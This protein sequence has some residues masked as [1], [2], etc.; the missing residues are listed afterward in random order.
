MDQS[1][2]GRGGVR[3]PLGVSLVS[4][5]FLMSDSLLLTAA[6]LLSVILLAIPLGRYMYRVYEGQ[7]FWATRALGG[8]ERAIYWLLNRK[9][10]SA[11]PKNA[12]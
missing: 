6:V 10:D 7:R 2:A 1:G 11:G 4:G 12:P 5:A 8:V 9:M 3:L